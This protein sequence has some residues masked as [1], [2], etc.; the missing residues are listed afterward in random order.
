MLNNRI[1][2]HSFARRCSVRSSRSVA[3]R[4]VSRRSLAQIRRTRRAPRAVAGRDAAGP[5]TTCAP[6]AARAAEKPEE[7]PTEAERVIDL[8][9]KKIAKLESVAAELVQEVNMLNQKYTIKGR[10]LKAP[11]T[12]V[13]LRL[14]VSGLADTEATTPSGL[15]RR[16]PLGLPGHL[17]SQSYRKLSIK[18]IL[19]R[20][21]SPELDPKTQG[22]GH[23]PDGARRP[24]DAACR[25]YARRSSSTRR[26]K[27]SST[28]RRSGNSAEPGGPARA[29]SAPTAARSAPAGFLPPYIPMDGTLY[30]GKDD[31]WPYKLVLVGRKPSALFET[32]RTRPGRPAHRR[33]ELDREDRPQRDRA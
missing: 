30:L 14:T 24:G 32:R 1:I 29:W 22:S 23:H 31:G 6:A 27:T 25:A 7:P 18:P 12:R 3:G 15:R 8:A 20:L 2:C 16:N 26:K 11:R 19:E 9:I 17:D 5:A 10:Y 28:A 13:Y 33:E 21:N 4:L